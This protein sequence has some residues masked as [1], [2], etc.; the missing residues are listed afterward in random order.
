MALVSKTSGVDGSAGRLAGCSWP[1]TATRAVGRAIGR[2]RVLTSCPAAGRR[3]LYAGDEARDPAGRRPWAAPAIAGAHKAVDR[4]DA[5][6]SVSGVLSG[7]SSEAAEAGPSC[8]LVRI[9]PRGPDGSGG[10]EPPHRLQQQGRQGQ[11]GE[12]Q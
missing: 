5:G 11:E 12:G 10:G 2:A 8:V 3:H 4:T 6:L 7:S 9:K 1:V